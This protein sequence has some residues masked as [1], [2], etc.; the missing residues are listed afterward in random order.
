MATNDLLFEDW[1]AHWRRLVTERENQAGVYADPA[2]WDKRARG[3]AAATNQRRDGF[4]E[5]LEPW[6]AAHRTALD[7]GAGAGRHAARLAERLD[8][9]TAVEPSEGMRAEIPY[10]ENMTIIA[11]PWELA[12]AAPA[13][14]VICCHVLYGVAEVETFLVK[15]D[16]AGRERVFVQMRVGQLRTPADPLWETLTGTARRRQPQFGDLYNVLVQLGYQP[17]VAI[18]RYEAHQVWAGE[19]DFVDEY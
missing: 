17:D 16:G 12:D 11:S 1:I 14:I 7:V 3:F 15:L 4:I 6:L 10:R 5:L 19:G 13:D 18:L 8:W 2:Y 9:V